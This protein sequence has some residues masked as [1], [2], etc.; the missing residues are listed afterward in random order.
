MDKDK[1]IS[2]IV[3]SLIIIIAIS[4]IVLLKI[5]SNKDNSSKKEASGMYSTGKHH[6]VIT[7]K[8]YG[9]IALE[10]DADIAPITVANFAKLVN[11][12]FYE[13]LT[14]HRI[15]NGFMMQGGAPKENQTAETIKGEFNENGINN[16]ISHVRGTISMARTTINDSAS[17]QFFIVHKDSLFLDGKYAGFGHVTSGMEIVDKICEN[18]PVTDDNGTVLE[19]DQPI[20]EKIVMID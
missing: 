18:T 5:N 8:D 10:L 2:I 14:F 13:G 7:I 11:D 4:A 20:I 17:S 3:F 9:D 1:L 16:S 15:M 12:N 19:K 6:A